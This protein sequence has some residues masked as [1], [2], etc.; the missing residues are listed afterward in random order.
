[1]RLQFYEGSYTFTEQKWFLLSLIFCFEITAP[2]SFQHAVR[3]LQPA[4]LKIG[5]LRP[6]MGK[7]RSNLASHDTYDN[8]TEIRRPIHLELSVTLAQNGLGFAART[9]KIWYVAIRSAVFRPFFYVFANR[10]RPKHMIDDSG[11][12]MWHKQKR[13]CLYDAGRSF[14]IHDFSPV[15]LYGSWRWYTF[16]TSKTIVEIFPGLPAT[17]TGMN[18]GSN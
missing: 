9:W 13:W 15:W 7:I 17:A 10:W 16:E 2:L 18:S 4:A 12:K 3:R 14:K 5:F 11:T 1:M 8:S 6:F